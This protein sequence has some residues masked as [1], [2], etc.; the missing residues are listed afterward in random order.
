MLR[1]SHTLWGESADRDKGP[2]LPVCLDWGGREVG[3]IV[4][5]ELVQFI[6]ILLLELDSVIGQTGENLLR[7]KNQWEKVGTGI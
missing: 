6:H 5:C 2:L 4:P 1:A 3:L 7:I